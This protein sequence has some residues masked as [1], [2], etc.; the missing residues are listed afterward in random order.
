MKLSHEIWFGSRVLCDIRVCFRSVKP[1][2]EGD[3]S[4]VSVKSREERIK[5]CALHCGFA[6]LLMAQRSVEGAS[7]VSTVTHWGVHTLDY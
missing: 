3:I 7:G 5:R 1:Q 2:N 6:K 4:E